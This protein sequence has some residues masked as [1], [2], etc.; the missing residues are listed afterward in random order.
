M[1]RTLIAA[2]LV[3][4]SGTLLA[5]ECSVSID[6]QMTL[7]NEILTITTEE[8]DVISI[9]SN[10]QLF[11]NGSELDLSPM[12][13]QWVQDYYNGINDAVPQA[14]SIAVEGVALASSAISEVFG[15]LLG[16]DS[17]AIE[18]VTEK[19]SDIG[20]KVHTSFYAEDGSI[21]VNSA[22]F[23]DGDMFGEQW[24]NEF[25]TAVEEVI[26]NSVGQL[27]VA[28]GTQMMFGGDNNS[29]D[30]DQRMA[31]FSEDFEKRIEAQAAVVEEKA[32]ALCIQVASID[33]AENKLQSNVEELTDLN[34]FT[35]D[36]DKRRM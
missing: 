35:V 20:D 16:Q 26:S 22:H 7:E 12:E 5:N 31:N 8:N 28:I 36:T 3:F 15:G 11:V 2:G 21:R 1:K 6:G 18:R 9:E 4:C 13:K 23:N 25:E 10:Y 33:H 30:F 29:E 14:A 19:L 17:Q 34:I 32:E 27:L 24:S